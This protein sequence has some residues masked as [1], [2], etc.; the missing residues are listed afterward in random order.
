MRKTYRKLLFLWEE[1]PTKP[2]IKITT[3]KVK[4]KNKK[5][6]TQQINT[7]KSQQD[8]VAFSSLLLNLQGA[9]SCSLIC[10][11]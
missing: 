10:N 9:D 1:S 2:I 4:K 11:A 3:S 5:L 6:S 7:S 8:K